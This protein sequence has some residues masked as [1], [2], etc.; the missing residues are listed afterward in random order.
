MLLTSDHDRLCEHSLWIFKIYVKRSR[1]YALFSYTPIKPSILTWGYRLLNSPLPKLFWKF[2]KQAKSEYA[3]IMKDK[4]NVVATAFPK[5]S[6][7]ESLQENE[8]SWNCLI[9]IFFTLH[10]ITLDILILFLR[11]AITGTRGQDNLW[12]PIGPPLKIFN[13]IFDF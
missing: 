2:Y 7:S 12:C 4:D 9:L 10:N 3:K 1:M 6:C 13:K 5:D 11:V 8:L